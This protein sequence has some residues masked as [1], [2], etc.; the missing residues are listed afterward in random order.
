[1]PCS[2]YARPGFERIERIEVRMPPHV[3]V[4]GLLMRKA[5]A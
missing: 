3:V 5:L 1:M 2:I 4:P